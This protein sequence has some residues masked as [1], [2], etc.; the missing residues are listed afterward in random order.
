MSRR[1]RSGN[2]MVV[3]TGG[4]TR[5]P[6]KLFSSVLPQLRL[7]PRDPEVVEMHE[8]IRRYGCWPPPQ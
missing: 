1:R 4:S 6:K 7:R 2:G 5:L 8:S 3:R